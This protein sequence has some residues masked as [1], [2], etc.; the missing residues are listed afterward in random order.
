MTLRK[1]LYSMGFEKPS[2][3]LSSE[4]LHIRSGYEGYSNNYEKREQQQR[5]RED[6]A[7]E[8]HEGRIR[9]TIGLLSSTEASCSIEKLCGYQH[10]NHF[11]DSLRCEEESS[12]VA[13]RFNPQEITEEQQAQ[14]QE[15]GNQHIT[16]EKIDKFEE[17]ICNENNL[18]YFD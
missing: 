9:S 13:V 4:S 10:P 7:Y 8:V 5:V 11:E 18:T 15:I 12:S 14:A 1:C 3:E 17:A 6:Q 16:E 2:K